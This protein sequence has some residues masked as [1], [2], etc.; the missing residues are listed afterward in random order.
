MFK[1]I[2]SYVPLVIG[3]LLALSSCKDDDDDKI[4]TYSSLVEVT[5]TSLQFDKYDM[6]LLFSID[7][8][9]TF[10]DYPL[11]K[12]GQKYQVKIHNAGADW[13]SQEEDIT[14]ENHYKFDWSGSDP[15]PVGTGDGE[16]AEFVAGKNNSVLVKVTDECPYSAA[17]WAGTY[18]AV[19]Q[20]GSTA[21]STKTVTITPDPTTPNRFILTGFYEQE[22][23][24]AYLDFDEATGSVKFPNQTTTASKNISESSGVYKSCTGEIVIKL[25]YDYTVSNT[26]TAWYYRLKKKS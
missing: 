21:G 8:G 14:A 6:N 16:V 13:I 4:K 9:K 20:K 23:L 11:L 12:P 22:G 24:T 19:V 10:V 17:D 15:K 26:L 18:S 3:A 7:E 2:Y 25:K 5:N 1:K